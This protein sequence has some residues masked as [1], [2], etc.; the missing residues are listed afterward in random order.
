MSRGRFNFLHL[1]PLATHLIGHL[2][3]VLATSEY[4]FQEWL[5]AQ[6]AYAWI[7]IVVGE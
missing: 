6:A 1:L 4:G 5:T 3:Q 7:P 2:L